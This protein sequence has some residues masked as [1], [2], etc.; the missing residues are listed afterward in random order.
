ML[1]KCPYNE[2]HLRL[3]KGIRPWAILTAINKTTKEGMMDIG[4]MV[5]EDLEGG[6]IKEVEKGDSESG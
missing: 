5:E 2:S 4:I 3:T 1:R 6:K